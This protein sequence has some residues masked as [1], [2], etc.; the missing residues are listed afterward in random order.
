MTRPRPHVRVA[1]SAR[2]QIGRVRQWAKAHPRLMRRA[3]FTALFGLALGGGLAAG[4][5]KA[6]CRDCPSIAQIYV[7]EPIRATKILAHDGKLVTELYLERRTPVD[8][9]S[10]PPYVPKAFVAVEDKRFYKHGGFDAIGIMRAARNLALR[11]VFGVNAYGGGSTIT[12]QLA[13]HMFTEE[14]GF[15][16]RPTRKLKEI[17]VSR[18]LESVYKKDQILAAY[19]NQ[20]HYGH[21]WHGIETAA[22]HYFGKP[23]VEINPAEAAL[24]AAIINAP[25]RYDPFTKPERATR[26]RN[27]VLALMAD[28]GYLTE[29][30]AKKWQQAPLPDSPRGADES[31]LAPYFVEWIRIQL[32]DRW[33]GDLYKEGLRIHTTLD[34]DM[35]RAAQAA[36]DSGW[37][38]IE[39]VPAFRHPKYADVIAKKNGARGNRTPYLQGVFIA[40]DPHT[41]D[42]RA[43]IGGR[44]FKDSKF[45]RATQ[46]LR[47]PGSV[48][49]PFV[50]TAAIAGG[51]PISHMIVDEPFSMPQGDGTIWAPQNFDPDYRGAINLRETLRHS[52]NIPTIKLGL[53]VGL[54]SVVQYARRLGIRTPIPEYPAVTIGS[55]EVIPLQVAE[56]Y[57]VFASTGYRPTARAVT[58][59]EDAQGRVLW[60]NRAQIEQVLDS[61]TTAVV[62]ELMRDVVDRGTGYAARDPGQGNLPYEIPAGGKTGTT[63]DNTNIWFVGYTPSLVALV[64]YGLDRPQRIVGNASGG[65]YAAPVW[66][67]FMR[68]VYY[69]EGRRLAKPEP[70]QFPSGVTMR[71]IDRTTGKLAT[72][73][74]PTEVI[75]EEVYVAGTEPTDGCD[76]HSPG[77]LGRPMPRDTI[78]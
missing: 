20:I 50:M 49:K 3:G 29:E 74:C 65:V 66:G 28:Q 7:W 26:R 16:R 67:K 75:V 71:R 41:G 73:F 17:K 2:R 10:L 46:A 78:R 62:R 69:G 15:E 11:K 22:Q 76:K 63:N 51:I 36:M 5:W 23:A 25:S 32:D 61:T 30:E 68:S 40:M 31:R 37:A 54:E 34:V 47:Q 19:I 27:T 35:Q 4:T 33:G 55:A 13:R 45:N 57:S 39:R 8:I 48:F 38:R 72:E 1:G 24:L 14:I 70:W 9:E 58:R 21:G 43:M 64:W 52:V 6:V 53:E 60:E 59:V 12:Q 42:I 44:D 77:L 18:E 56:A